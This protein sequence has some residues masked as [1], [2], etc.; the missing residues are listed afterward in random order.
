MKKLLICLLLFPILSA[1]GAALK[2]KR[3]STQ[4]KLDKLVAKLLVIPGQQCISKENASHLEVPQHWECRME[5]IGEAGATDGFGHNANLLVETSTGAVETGA[6]K[7]IFM[8]YRNSKDNLSTEYF[9]SV[10]SLDGELVRH[11]A[12][13]GKNEA[14]GSP[15]KGTGINIPQDL[16]SKEIG[17]RFKHEL[18]FWLDGKY[19]KK[20][21]KS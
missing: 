20:Q 18:Q 17:S 10:V 19:R 3:N 11:L 16:E 15:I 9:T 5:N 1:N 8:T 14:D 12:T 7:I 21:K 2:Q 4:K 13:F 6:R